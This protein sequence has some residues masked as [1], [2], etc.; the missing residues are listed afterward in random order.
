MRAA[1]PEMMGLLT[2]ESKNWI[3]A[4]SYRRTAKNR[5]HASVCSRVRSGCGRSGGG[6]GHWVKEVNNFVIQKYPKAV[7]TED[8][9]KRNPNEVEKGNDDDDDSSPLLSPQYS[10]RADDR[11]DGDDDHNCPD[12]DKDNR[13]DVEQF[14]GDILCVQFASSLEEIHDTAKYGGEDEKNN[15]PNERKA[16]IDNIKNS[17]ELYVFFHGECPLNGKP[18]NHAC[19]MQNQVL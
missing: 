4:L 6:C 10:D 15:R 7:H 18:G 2:Q 19:F 1:I 11:D 9:A 16:A 3:L 14:P 17:N 13:Q 8:R 5:D 12:N